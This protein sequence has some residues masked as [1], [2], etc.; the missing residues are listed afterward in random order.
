MSGPAPVAAARE[1][2]AAPVPAQPTDRLPREETAPP[3]AQRRLRGVLR[4]VPGR[5][6]QVTEADHREAVVWFVPD[7]GGPVRAG[8]FTMN[9]L[10]K[11]FDPPVLAVPV[12]STVR[13][14]NGD[15]VLHNVYSDSAGHAFDLGL[16]GPGEAPTHQFG[17][18]GVVDVHCNVHRRMQAKI[19]VVESHHIGRVLPD[20]RFVIDAVPAV[21]GRLIAWH[22]RG[23]RVERLIAAD[24]ADGL[25]IELPLIRPRAEAFERGARR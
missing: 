23:E 11:G 25:A 14:P 20:G 4:L 13:F 16:Y 22:P 1:A 10:Q 9:T 18:A 15:P 21:G 8:T 17:R 5:G 12:G 7:G 6:Q 24:A 3:V 2:S 19:V